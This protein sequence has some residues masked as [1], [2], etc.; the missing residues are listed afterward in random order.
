MLKSV[1]LSPNNDI[2]LFFKKKDVVKMSLLVAT[3]SFGNS[4][5]CNEFYKDSKSISSDKSS[6]KYFLLIIFLESAAIF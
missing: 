3:K 6:K 1:T 5:L 2:K 4:I